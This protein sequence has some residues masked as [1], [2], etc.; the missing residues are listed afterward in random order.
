MNFKWD[1]IQVNIHK[2]DEKDFQALKILYHN[3]K[4]I[5][6][7]NNRSVELAT[8]NPDKWFD[9]F[10]PTLFS[11]VDYVS[12]S[13]MV[14]LYYFEDEKIW[15][16]S[17]ETT[18]KDFDSYEDMEKFFIKE[19]FSELVLFSICKYIDLDSLKESWQ[20]RFGEIKTKEVERDKKIKYLTNGIDNN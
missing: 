1:D 3:C 16:K 19:R 20:I 10:V 8:L 2:V 4:R 5:A 7:D 13:P 18:W 17:L 11:S 14:S 6:N 9:R 15:S 12:E